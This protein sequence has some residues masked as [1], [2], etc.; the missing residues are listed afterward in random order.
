MIIYN[1]R[2]HREARNNHLRTIISDYN[3][4]E[5]IYLYTVTT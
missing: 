1:I 4:F 5:F 3:R 2:S